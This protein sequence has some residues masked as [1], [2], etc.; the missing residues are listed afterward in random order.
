MLTNE[1]TLVW[2]PLARGSWRLCDPRYAEGDAERLV[3]YVER[4]AGG[5]F[6]AVWIGRR[7]APSWHVTRAAVLLEARRLSRADAHALRKSDIRRDDFHRSEALQDR[8][9]VLATTSLS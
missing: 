9:R 2:E 7:A 6:E 3:A 4:G 1:R 8:H 5:G